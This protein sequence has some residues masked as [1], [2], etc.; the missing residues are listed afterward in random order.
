MNSVSRLK[1]KSSTSQHLLI[2]VCGGILLSCFFYSENFAETTTNSLITTNSTVSVFHESERDPFSPVGYKKPQKSGVSAVT[3]VEPK[4]KIT[5]ISIVGNEATATLDNGQVL[6]VG[7]TYKYTDGKSTVEY[8]VTG[9]ADDGV[10]ILYE[11]REIEYK[12][13][14][15]DIEIFKEKEESNENANP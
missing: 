7:G 15:Q 1:M 14:G 3:I 9:I 12:F 11:G 5:G 8:K 10:N 4:L 2:G 6:E 13:K